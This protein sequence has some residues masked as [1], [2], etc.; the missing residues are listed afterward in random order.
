M[1][2]EFSFRV[3]ETFSR[4]EVFSRRLEICL[5][6]GEFRLTIFQQIIIHSKTHHLKRVSRERMPHEYLANAETLSNYIYSKRAIL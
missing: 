2:V 6:V 1:V 3:V 4:G 5:G